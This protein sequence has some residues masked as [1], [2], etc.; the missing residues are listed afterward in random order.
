MFSIYRNALTSGGIL[1]F[2]DDIFNFEIAGTATRYGMCI[3][4]AFSDY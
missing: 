2:W 1:F 4:W 3:D